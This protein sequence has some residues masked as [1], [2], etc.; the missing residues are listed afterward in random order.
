MRQFE[1]CHLIEARTKRAAF[2]RHLVATLSLHAV[3]VH[4]GRF[5]E[6]GPATCV[7]ADWISLQAVA[8][9]EKLFASIRQIT[10]TRTTVIWITSARVESFMRPFQTIAVPFSGTEVSLFRLDQS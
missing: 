8:L 4:R 10:S 7:V 3:H 6:V 5:E 1:K 2:L 9:T